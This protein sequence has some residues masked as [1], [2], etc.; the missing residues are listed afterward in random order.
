MQSQ[1]ATAH[2][3]S[4]FFLTDDGIRLHYLLWPNPESASCCLL[5]HG[6]TN[7]AH[8]W[9]GLAAHLQQNHTV[10]ALDLRGHG[11]S[12]RDPKENYTHPR[13]VEDVYALLQQILAPRIHIISHSLGARVAMMMLAQKEFSPASFT[14]I[15][16][17]PEVRAIGVNKIREDAYN[18]PDTFSS[19]DAFRDYLTAIYLFARPDR[20]RAMAE[21][22]LQRNAEGQLVSK[23]DPAFT[24][25]LWKSGAREG[26]DQRLL[27]QLTDELW[28]SLERIK[29]PCLILRGQA[30]AI[31]AKE[32]AEKMKAVIPDA[33]L[34]T[35]SR[36]GHA[37]MVDNP[38]EF[39]S[40]VRHFIESVSSHRTTGY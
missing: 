21:H 7:D 24:R 2:P 23:T 9:D 37:L 40:V 38:D 8:I 33:R 12:G 18:V 15:D 27:Y 16:T 13:L 6:F 31:L 19:V 5:L 36:A 20:I 39:E 22:G 1:P 3:E 32:V 35:I 10:I 29:A 34:Q 30:S 11:D 28:R 26:E 25:A 4:H 14:I 17:G